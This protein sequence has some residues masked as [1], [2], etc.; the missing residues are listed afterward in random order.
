GNPNPPRVGLIVKKN[1]AGQWM[2][3]NN[4]DWTN[5]VSGAQ[6][7]RSGRPIGWD[8]PDRDLAIINTADFSVRYATRL[9]NICMAVGV[10]PASGEVAVVGTDATNEVRFEPVLAGR[11]LR[12][13]IARVNPVG[14]TTLGIADL[15]PH[16][17][18]TR[19]VPFVPIAQTERKKSIGDPRGIAWNPAGTRAYITGMGSNNLIVVDAAGARAGLA[20]TIHVGQG[21][22]GVVYHAGRNRLY[23]LNRFEA[24]VSV[25]DAVKEK[26]IARVPF[27][28]P[29]P[30]VIRTGRKHLYDTHRNSGL[31]HV[32]CASC[33]VD[34]RTDRLAWDLGDPSGT[35]KVFNQNCPLAVL[36]NNCENWHPMKGPMATQTLQDIIGLEPHHWRGDRDGLEEFADAFKGL[37]GDDGKLPSPEMQEFE[38]FLATIHFPPN[39]Y[40]NFDNTL[41]TNLPLP[42]H[43]TSGRYGPA[44]QPLPNGNA[45]NG[46]NRYRTGNLDNPF[47]CVSCHTLPT[48]AGTNFRFQQ[49]TFVDQ[50]PGPNGEFHH[51]IV[52]VDGSTNVSIKVPQIRNMYDKV[53]MELTQL[54]NL[55]GFGFL[56]D[57]SVDSLARFVSEPV[58]SLANDQD[59]AD[60]VAFMLAFSG[61]DLPTGT[62][63]NILELP[64]PPS[65]DAH[66]AVGA[67]LTVT[68]SNKSDPA[69]SSR[70]GEMKA[71]ADAG[72]V[73][74][75]VKGRRG[76]LA[77]GYQYTGAGALQSDRAAEVVSFAALVAGVEAGSEM[78]FTVVPRGSERRIGIDRDED[79]YFDRD[80]LDACSHPADALRVP[81]PVIAADLDCD[82]DVDSDDLERLGQCMT[83]SGVSA[84]TGCVSADLDGDGD[85]DQFDFGLLQRCIRG[86]GVSAEPGCMD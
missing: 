52:S 19:D 5:L 3:D 43:F 27:Y 15:N 32:S 71:L 61:S 50:P 12:V 2:D 75:V 82:A 6:A 80:E 73:G 57:G 35:V 84:A 74:L 33:H 23:V 36:G 70:L 14:P 13:N 79:G 25:I 10:N 9:M 17:T 83:G 41:P 76:G 54:E 30:Q 26:E 11:F 78:T 55:A 28:D 53:G 63:A 49:F 1:A 77:R 46:L 18:Y 69:V 51:A 60:M 7:A 24:S 59:V 58:F 42:G 29:T 67:Q 38:D 34:A 64:G 31:G 66:A 4:H 40:R 47:N 68:E 72:K 86:P 65:R 62:P 48:G 85:V 21:P 81:G 37:L 45:V 56:H 16:L 44:G 20:P 22:T 8:L 39:P